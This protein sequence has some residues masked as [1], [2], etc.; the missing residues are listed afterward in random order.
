MRRPTIA[1]RRERGG[2]VLN[3]HQGGG[4]GEGEGEGGRGRGEVCG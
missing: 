2:H 3:Q 1:G 4:K